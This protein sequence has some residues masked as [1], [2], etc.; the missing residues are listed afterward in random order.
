MPGI[1]DRTRPVMVNFGKRVR[2][3]RRAAGLSQLEL[4]RNSRM[5]ARFIQEIEHGRSNPSL[6]TIVLLAD[7]LEC[8]LWDMFPRGLE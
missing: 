5:T 1:K 8:S 3:L 6:E 4:S 2:E 7:A